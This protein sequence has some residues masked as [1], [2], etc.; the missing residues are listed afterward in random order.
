MIFFVIIMNEGQ[1]HQC[2]YW[3]WCL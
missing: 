3:I 1:H 2:Q